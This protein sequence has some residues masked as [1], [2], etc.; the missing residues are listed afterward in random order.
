M[1]NGPLIRNSRKINLPILHPSPVGL[2]GREIHLRDNHVSWE[3]RD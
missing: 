3:V 1:N 2:I